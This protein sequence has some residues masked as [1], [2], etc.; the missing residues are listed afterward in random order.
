MSESEA[1]GDVRSLLGMQTRAARILVAIYALALCVVAISTLDGTSAV[2]PI[3]I[4][5]LVLV[6]ATV[7]L[8]TVP[9]DPLPPVPTV[10][11]VVAGPLA[12]ALMLAVMPVP[13]EVPLQ[14]WTHGAGTT[15]LCF[16][17]V[18][19]RWPAAWAGLAGMGAVYG[20]WAALTDQGFVHGF[21]MVAIDVAP[22]GMATLFSFTLR[23]NGAAVFALRQAATVKA[24]ALSAEQAASE[25]RDSRLRQLDAE[26]R[27]LLQHIADGTLTAQ[28]RLEC[29]LL[30]AQLRDR[31]RAPFLVTDTITAA[32]RAA[33]ERGTE[34]TFIDDHGLD[35]AP[36]NLQSEVRAVVTAELSRAAG[37]M[38]TVRILPPGRRSLASIYTRNDDRENRRDITTDGA[39]VIASTQ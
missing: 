26:A 9:G 4:G 6:A 19:G 32:A 8:I 22:L 27:P 3:A 1:P 16:M 30:E 25:V 35:D 10:L 11:L 12:C 24:A 13:L 31:L 15:I 5:V 23:P 39:H 21:V 34:V 17:C 14:S 20:A 2:W 38:L 36:E 7:A 37:G 33:R 28:G 29:D 18:R